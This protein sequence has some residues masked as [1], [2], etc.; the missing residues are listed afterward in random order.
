MS[1]DAG[2]AQVSLDIDGQRVV[3]KHGPPEPVK[4]DSGRD[5]PGATRSA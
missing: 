2:M 4:V 5:R 3:Y 1:L